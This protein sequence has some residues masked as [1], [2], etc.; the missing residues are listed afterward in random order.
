MPIPSERKRAILATAIFALAITVLSYA[1]GCGPGLCKTNVVLKFATVLILLGAPPITALI[2]F[3][4]LGRG[5]LWLYA[6]LVGVGTFP[7]GTV[8]AYFVFLALRGTA[9]VAQTGK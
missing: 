1:L 6:A 8:V 5:F 7:F 4:S 3:G 2:T 9:D